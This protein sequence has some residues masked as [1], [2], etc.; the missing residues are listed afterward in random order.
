MTNRETFLKKP[1]IDSKNEPPSP[2]K[3]II[4]KEKSTLSSTPIESLRSSI[5][6]V[7]R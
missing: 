1:S 7:N 3:K 4:N 6:K 2:F 5:D